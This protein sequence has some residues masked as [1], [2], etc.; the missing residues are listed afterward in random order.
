MPLFAAAEP[1]AV[2][3]DLRAL[4]M[5]AF[6][7]IATA[8]FAS[9]D[10]LLAFAGPFGLTMPLVDQWIR[11]GYL[12]FGTVPADGMGAP[13]VGY[14]ALTP[15]GARELAHARGSHVVGINTARMKRSS[16]KRRHDVAV[17]D[18][19]LAVLALA[20]TGR[21]ALR[22]IETDEK[23]LAASVLLAEPGRAPERV[24][25][26]ADALI[27]ADDDRGPVGLLVEVD[28]GT[29]AVKRMAAKYAGYLAWRRA[30]GPERDFALRALR[31]LTLVP[32]LR[33]LRALHA[34]ALAANG[35]RRSGFL[36]FG[37]E[38]DATPVAAER[39]LG[40][41]AVVLGDDASRV[42]VLPSGV[43]RPPGVCAA[44]E[45]SPEVHE[46]SPIG[47]GIPAS[48]HRPPAGAAP[49]QAPLL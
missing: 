7:A 42:P 30:G 26:Q 49:P 16:Q 31:V 40:P 29:I 33:R 15:S 13:E 28:R 18:L 48:R 35:G 41:V 34:A 5:E 47:L 32:D 11:A 39:L 43:P 24:A 2:P 12:H 6:A 8:R 1:L 4:A 9:L 38:G 44:R 23:K 19:A 21:V 46:K 27:V 10:S 14:V 36:L 3:P 22:G 37:L 20:R 17:G 45:S 25:L